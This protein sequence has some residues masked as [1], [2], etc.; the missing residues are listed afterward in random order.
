MKSIERIFFPKFVDERGS[1]IS[2]EFESHVSF[3]IKRAYYIFNNSENHRRGFHAHKKLKQLFVVMA[4]SCLIDFDDGKERVSYSLDSPDFGVV[5]NGIFWREM[6]SFTPDCVLC[7]F[8]DHEYD[9]A[10][11]INDYQE[12]LNFVAGSE[13]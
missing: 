8:A 10:D 7:V 1:L 12:F 11:Y 13:L 6:H 5:V 9:P 3:D 2:I 4:G